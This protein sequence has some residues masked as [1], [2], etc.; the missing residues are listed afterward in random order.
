[1]KNKVF[2]EYLN[3]N[4]QTNHWG[5]SIRNAGYS[6]VFAGEVYPGPEH[7]SEYY[8]T[9]ERGRKLRE[10][11]LILITNGEGIFESASAKRQKIKAGSVIF[12]FKYEWHRYRPLKKTGWTEYWLGYDGDYIES[13]YQNALFDNSNPVVYIGDDTRF[14]QLM[15]H[16]LSLLEDGSPG[17]EKIVASYVPVLL[18]TIETI[19]RQKPH[20]NN[21]TE[22]DIRKFQIALIENFQH[23]INLEEIAT[24]MDISYSWMR[25]KFKQV[26]GIS[27]NQYILQLRLQ[28]ARDLLT[29]TDNQIKYISDECGFKSPF[30]FS[31]YFKKD[32]GLSPILFRKKYKN[33]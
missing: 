25:K 23:Q 11:Q 16:I 27:P 29:T 12:L 5:I 24:S 18:S 20:Q 1:M 2:R 32:T 8:F 9:W 28:K 6:K 33:S 14:T 15:H 7:P 17:I 13:I 19:I 10:Y 26:V 30:Y 22:K 21:R 4:R 31:K 3:I